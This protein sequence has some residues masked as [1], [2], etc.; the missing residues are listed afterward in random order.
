MAIKNY[1]KLV[2]LFCF[3]QAAVW[4]ETYP[5]GN[6]TTIC[7]GQ[8]ITLNPFLNAVVFQD[9]L[10]ITYH[11]IQGQTQ[12]VGANKVYMHSGYQETPFGPIVAWVGN[13][14]QDDGLGLMKNIGNDY[15][16]ITI[17]V[18]NY[19]GIAQGTTVNALSMVFRNADGTQTGK[20][21]SGNDIFLELNPIS[22]AFSGVSGFVKRDNIETILWNTGATNTS[23]TVNTPGNYSFIV[24]DTA[25]VSYS[26]D[27]TISVFGAQLNLGNDVSLCGSTSITLDAGAGFNNYT[28]STGATAQSITV[29]QAG[30]YSVSVQS[31]NCTAADT[32]Q[33]FSTIGNIAPIDLGNDLSICGTGS[34][35]LNAN[36]ILSPFGDSLSI[37]YN[38]NLGQSGLVGA[39]KVYMYAGL[40]EIPFGPVTGWVGNWGLDDGIGQMTAMGNDVWKITINIPSYF[41]VSSSL[42]INALSMVFRNADGSLTG[43]D[44]NGN[45]IFLVLGSSPNSAFSGVAG[46]MTTSPYTSILWSTG[47]TISTIGVNTS[48]TYSIAVGTNLGCTLYDTVQVSLGVLPFVDAGNSQSICDGQS[49]LLD[50]GTTFVTY[51]W[52]TGDTTTSITVSQSGSYT[53]TVTNANGCTGVDVINIAVLPEP[54]ALFTYVINASGVVNFTSTSSNAT[55]YNWDMNGDGV[56]DSS[57][58]NPFYTYLSNGTFNVRLIVT[59][60]CG[61]DT[62][63]TPIAITTG[64]ANQQLANSIKLYPNPAHDF[65]VLETNTANHSDIDFVLIDL[66]GNKAKIGRIESNEKAK[67]ID[68]SDLNKGLYLLQLTQD[69]QFKTIK[70]NKL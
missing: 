13:W 17:H 11:A 12:L 61:T 63:I 24:T 69:N 33:I 30:T 40:Q 43:K 56:T 27:I 67:R 57:N 55:T 6:D 62:L 22:S 18:N 29:S 15:W 65:V 25:G 2:V 20:D 46:I 35:S 60:N 14:G 9:S 26:D 16:R 31:G 50:A 21:D 41:N 58:P 48:G 68:L 52:S 42:S 28:W 70:I 45:D 3:V 47:E 7:S 34:T 4:A 10:V 44:D 23:I 59:N 8:S 51:N 49:V 64:I 37:I 19:Y 32:I 38:A 5:L 53:I 66:I 1:L 36:I 39:N 54:N